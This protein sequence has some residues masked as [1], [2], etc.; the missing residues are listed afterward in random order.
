MATK[1]Q[2]QSRVL[3]FFRAKWSYVTTKTVMRD[4]PLDDKQVLDI[5][6]N[7][8]FELGCDPSRPQ[9][10]KCVTVANLIK[11]LQDT[12]FVAHPNNIKS[13]ARPGRRT[14][15]RKGRKKATK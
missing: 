6:T 2:I 12:R 11:L 4:L 13:L 7:L 8:A 10:L 14:T 3:A 15:A 1:E 9:I 5:G